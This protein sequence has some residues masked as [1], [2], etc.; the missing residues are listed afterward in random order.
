MKTKT[1]PGLRAALRAYAKL[2]TACIETLAA[3]KTEHD[4]SL[5]RCKLNL[6]MEAAETMI[7]GYADQAL[8]EA[9]DKIMKSLTDPEEIASLVD[10]M[11]LTD[12]VAYARKHGVIQTW[13]DDLWPEKEAELR[14]AV[15]E[16]MCQQGGVEG[17]IAQLTE[18]IKDRTR[19]NDPNARHPKDWLD[20]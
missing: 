15:T 6:A 1:N 3:L 17:E 12:I 11:P 2:R 7:D 18:E 13:L 4:D 20:R 5:V 19:S 14:A 10:A 16:D 8:S 9:L